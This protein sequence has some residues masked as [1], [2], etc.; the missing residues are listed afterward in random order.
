MVGQRQ[1]IKDNPPLIF[2]WGQK[3]EQ[4]E[5]FAVA[6][7]SFAEYRATLQDDRRHLLDHYEL[8]DVA[9]VVTVSRANAVGE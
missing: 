7:A 2:H 4:A 3:Q 5:F 9:A 8:K 6:Q 1:V